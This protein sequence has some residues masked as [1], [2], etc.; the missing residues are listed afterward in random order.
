MHACRAAHSC[1][2]WPGRQDTFGVCAY[3]Q[4]P[5]T[6]WV[7]AKSQ[8]TVR[9]VMAWSSDSPL[10]AISQSRAFL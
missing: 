1:W 8:A 3:S 6:T 7:T 5:S 2:H 9:R 10:D 4:L